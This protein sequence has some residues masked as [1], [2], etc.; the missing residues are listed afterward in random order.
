MKK[1]S[2]KSVGNREVAVRLHGAAL[3]L[4]RRLRRTDV[5]LGVSTARLSALSVLVFGGPKTVS[6]LAAIEQVSQP[7]MTSLVQGLTR[8]GL[9]RS[10]GDPSDRRVRRLRVTAAG[11]RLLRRGQQ[12]R[13]E[14]LVAMMESLGRQDVL[15]LGRAADLVEQMLAIAPDAP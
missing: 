12:N 7:T 6:E 15:A 11:E 10:E 14:T 3:R 8:Q 13:V 5:E 9:V 4:L 1:S 2:A